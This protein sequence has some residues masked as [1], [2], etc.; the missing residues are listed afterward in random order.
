MNLT[1]G[2]QRLEKRLVHDLT[3]DRHRDLTREQLAHTRKKPL[4]FTDQGPNV[5][6]LD[7]ELEFS[8]RHLSEWLGQDHASHIKLHTGR[9]WIVAE[10]GIRTITLSRLT[11]GRP[12]REAVTG[13]DR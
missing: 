4:Q 5:T 8:A 3:V 13:G 10:K 7:L 9:T 12:G 11:P 1:L 2:L 6:R